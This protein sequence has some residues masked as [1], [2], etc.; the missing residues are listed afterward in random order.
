ML[1]RRDKPSITWIPESQHI[2]PLSLDHDCS[3]P[4]PTQGHTTKTKGYWNRDRRRGAFLPYLGWSDPEVPGVGCE[5]QRWLCSPRSGI[6]SPWTQSS[7][8][9]TS[10]VPLWIGRPPPEDPSRAVGSSLIQTS[11]S[12]LSV[13]YFVLIV[14]GL[15]SASR[16]TA[17]HFSRPKQLTWWYAPSTS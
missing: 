2:V 3:V 16:Y 12:F 10:P 4:V 8:W 5:W 14:F 7:D 15:L 11:S 1:A 13:P 17:S 9:G 6:Q